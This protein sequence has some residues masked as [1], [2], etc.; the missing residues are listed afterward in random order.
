MRIAVAT[1]AR[2]ILAVGVDAGLE[3]IGLVGVAGLALNR[4]NLV[5]V[6]IAGDVGVAGIAAQRAV[7]ARV[8]LLP[9]YTYAVSLRIL[10][11]C[12]GVACQ[13]IGLCAAD[14][15]AGKNNQ[16][17][18]RSNNFAAKSLHLPSSFSR[19]KKP[20]PSR[21]ASLPGQPAAFSFKRSRGT[22]YQGPPLQK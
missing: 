1:G 16:T 20:R 5:G 15:R 9:V 8:E 18:Q 17:K 3:L 19:Q 7:N 22:H 21:L 13:A 14:R 4:S 2:M 6:G 12:V 10:Q 11:C